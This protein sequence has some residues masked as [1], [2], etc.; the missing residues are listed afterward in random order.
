MR[1]IQ[2]QVTNVVALMNPG[3]VSQI[4]VA[5]D[6]ESIV[7]SLQPNQN[8]KEIAGEMGI[9]LG[10]GYG[11]SSGVT[12]DESRHAVIINRNTVHDKE[13]YDLLL[14]VLETC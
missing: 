1:T 6:L 10:C 3:V 2:E 8:A 9:D 5:S 7:V 13:A 4:S 12:A 14:R 11:C